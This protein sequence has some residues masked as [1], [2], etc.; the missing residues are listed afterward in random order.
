MHQARVVIA[1]VEILEDA[2]EDL[3]FLRGQVDASISGLEKLRAQEIGKE[4]AVRQH[5]LVGSE[6]SL[7]ASD[8]NRDDGTGSFHQYD[9]HA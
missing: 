2:A 6:Q 3:G 8:S 9:V 1:F 4:R 5:V 7:F